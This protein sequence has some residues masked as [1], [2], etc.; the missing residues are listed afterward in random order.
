MSYGGCSLVNT[1]TLDSLNKVLQS[2]HETLNDLF[3]KKAIHL[4]K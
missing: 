2:L 4:A 3:I 1:V